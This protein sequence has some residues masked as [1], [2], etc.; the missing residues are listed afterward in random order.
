VNFIMKKD[1]EGVQFDAQYGMYE[2]HN[3][4]DGPG[5]TNLRDVIKQNSLTNPS[6][7]KLPGSYVTDGESTSSTSFW[8]PRP[9]M[10]RETS[11]PM[12]AFATI[13]RS[14]KRIAITP[15]VH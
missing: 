4:F 7:F 5:Q 15:L 14:C 9:K 13:R 8:A 12:P 2:H 11:P 10:A 1:F 6:Q 3:S